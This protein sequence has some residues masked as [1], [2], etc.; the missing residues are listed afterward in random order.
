MK[1]V[2]LGSKFA[3]LLCALL[4]YRPRSAARV[5]VSRN[6]ATLRAGGAVGGGGGGSGVLIKK[7]EERYYG[8]DKNGRGD[9]VAAR[10]L[11]GDQQ[12]DGSDEEEEKS[13]LRHCLEFLCLIVA[14]GGLCI[15][16]FILFS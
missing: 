2:T 11:Q 5:G 13:A 1:L 10:A 15:V 16:Y 8:N 7:E 14:I 3:L 12:Y 6:A 9:G 4:A